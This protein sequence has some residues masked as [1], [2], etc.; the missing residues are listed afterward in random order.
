MEGLTHDL[1]QTLRGLW[2]RPGFAAITVVTL[3]L[4]IG[5]STAIFSAVHAV[6]FRDLPYGNPEQIV[7]VFHENALT[8]ERGFGLSPANAR[9]IGENSELL[10]DVAVAEPWSLDLEIDGRA[11]AVRAWAVSEGFFDALGVEPLFG[12]S[13]VEADYV[14][15]ESPVVLVGHRSWQNRFGGDSALVG[16]TLTFQEGPATV[17]GILG[18]DFKLPDEAE[19]WVPRM[20][21][22]SDGVQRSADYMLGVGRL[23][24]GASMEQAQTELTRIG[25]SLAELHPEDNASTTFRAASLREHLFGD[26]QTPLLVLLAAVGLVLLIACGNVAGLMLARGARRQ[27]EYALRGALGASTTRLIRQITLESAVLAALGCVLGIGI[28]YLGVQVI[29]RLG[30]DHLPRIDEVAIDSS[31]LLFAVAVSAVSALLSGIAPS[32]KLSRPELATALSDGSRSA[33]S[34]PGSLRVRNRLVVVEVAAAVVLLVGAGL[35]S[36][37]FTTLLDEELGFDPTGRLAVQVFAYDGYDS[38]EDRAAFVRQAIENLESLP[39]VS[40]V[41]LTSSVPSA[42]DGQLA[43]IDI[44]LRFTIG[45]RPA[46]PEGQE[47]VAAISQVS[48]GFFDVMQMPIV[49]GR[50]FDIGDDPDGVPV[51]IVNEAL[52]RRYFG[53]GSP[54]GETVVIGFRPIPREVVGVVANV[55]PQGYE[56]EPRPEVYFPM[57]QFG[58]SSLTFVLESEVEAATLVT[59]AMDAIW[60]AN[61]AQSIWGAATL[62]GLLDDWLTERT[63]NL[64]LMGSLAAIALIL[65]GIGIYGLVSFSVEERVAE[66]GIR[67][68]LGGGAAS[69]LTMVLVEGTRLAAVGLALGLA[70]AYP[71]TRFIQ[72]MLHGVEAADPVVLMGLVVAVMAV[73]AV[74]A[75]LVPALRAVRADPMTALRT[76]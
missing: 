36:R 56:S 51:V 73:A 15:T 3:G 69:I 22:D 9:D 27:R 70:L 18:P 52:A 10:T 39:G 29:G 58:T 50:A 16:R 42:T 2:K 47:P 37:S 21:R 38:A 53:D 76:E 6:L 26:V 12:R 23:R 55:R 11:Q 63:F 30:P 19:F 5:A 13:F 41:A 32:I 74:A 46:P 31:V 17:A 35:L 7:V 64:L 28:T 14:G 61:P 62:D 24:P 40:G 45:D 1:R 71:L 44:D 48:P 65:S 60:N 59:P 25:A 66:M 68:A 20:P 43:S 75:A 33:T 8:G 49:D 4:G 34:G 72:G 67:R 57:S 54:I